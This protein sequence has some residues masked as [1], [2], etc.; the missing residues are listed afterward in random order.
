MYSAREVALA[1]GVD[2]RALDNLIS[3]GDNLFRLRGRQGKS[4]LISAEQA[5]VMA[6]ALLLRRDLSIPLPR[7]ARLAAEL[8]SSDDG[9]VPVGALGTLTFDTVRLESLVRTAL[10]DAIQDRTTPRRG[11]PPQKAARGAPIWDAPRL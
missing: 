9:R 8:L 11:R 3:R 5:T 1:I 2:S 6:A 10:A 4:R 7:A